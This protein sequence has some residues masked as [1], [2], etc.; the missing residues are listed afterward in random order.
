M[1]SYFNFFSKIGAFVWL[2]FITSILVSC[3]QIPGFTQSTGI[4]LLLNHY[5]YVFSRPNS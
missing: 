2:I 3:P 1:F 4:I 5:I